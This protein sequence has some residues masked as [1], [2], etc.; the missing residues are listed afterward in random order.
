[1]VSAQAHLP[2]RVLVVD[3]SDVFQHVLSVMV[4]ATP[5]FEVVGTASS[6]REALHLI[7]ALDPQL[8]LIDLQLPE[9]EGIK[10]ARRL[11]E[12]HPHLVVVLLTA[13]R[14]VSL[15]LP[16]LTIVDR[17][18]VSPEWLVAFWRRNG[19]R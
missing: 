7:D 8:V 5:T 2:V 13:D 4:A 19:D 3:E 18:D 17:Q 11:R 12:Q 10:T 15:A 6:G 9:H 14:P 1:V 16:S